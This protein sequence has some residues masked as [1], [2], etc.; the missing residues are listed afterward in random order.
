MEN[1]T[2]NK[3]LKNCP[4]CAEEIQEEAIICKHCGREIDTVAVK[5][6]DDKEKEK[7]EKNKN[8]WTSK[9]IGCVVIFILFW[10]ILIIILTAGGD[11]NSSPEQVTEKQAV[12]Q[13]WYTGG[14]L[15]K[16]TIADWKVSNNENKLATSADMMAVV[17]N[18]VS[19]DE[20]RIRAEALTEC[21]DEATDIDEMVIDESRVSEVGALCII[22][23]GYGN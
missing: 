10:I 23:L 18:T 2:H 14:T 1:Q 15:H 8:K 7:V 5:K 3:Q 12:D 6:E 11:G 16:D 21:I 19:M 13:E 17:D 4:F 22:S 9:R 20:L